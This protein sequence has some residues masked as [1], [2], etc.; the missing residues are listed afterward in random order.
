MHEIGGS[1][2]AFALHAG[3]IFHQLSAFIHALETGLLPMHPQ[4]T[5]LLPMETGLLPK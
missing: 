5:G 3:A 1:L 4:E 2:H